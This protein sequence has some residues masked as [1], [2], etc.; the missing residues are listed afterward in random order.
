MGGQKSHM[1]HFMTVE[2]ILK[3]T[4]TLRCPG[5]GDAGSGNGNASYW[6]NNQILSFSLG[7]MLAGDMQGPP[8]LAP[9]L[10]TFL[11]YD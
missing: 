2:W 3:G 6:T 1:N 5:D 9:S 10:V 7:N 8:V 4:E 11:T